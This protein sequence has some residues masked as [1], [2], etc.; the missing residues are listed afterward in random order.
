VEKG[1]GIGQHELSSS[2][3][4]ERSKGAASSCTVGGT[5][6]Q[7]VFISA[8][9]VNAPNLLIANNYERFTTEFDASTILRLAEASCNLYFRSI[10]NLEV[11]SF[12]V[13]PCRIGGVYGDQC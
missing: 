1:G 12:S 11:A 2:V 10:S 13:G 3:L 6:I 5:A 9:T 4:Q 7:I 8:V